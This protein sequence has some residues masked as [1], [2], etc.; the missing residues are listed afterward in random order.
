MDL[1]LTKKYRGK[2]RVKAHYDLQTKD[3]I[4]DDEGNLDP[5]FGDFYLSGRSGIE[6]K[7]GTGSELGCYIPKLQLG[8]NILKSYYDSV[9]GNRGDKSVDKIVSELK[10]GGYVNDVDILSTEIFFTFDADHLDAL[11][12]IIK[13]KTSG[14]SISPFSTRNL[15]KKPYT[16]P[17]TDMDRYK[18]AKDG[19]SGLEIARLNEEFIA[20][21]FDS[22]F[23]T[24][25]R[26][27][28]LKPIQY[29][30]KEK[31]WDKYCN[32]IEESKNEY[33]N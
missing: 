1:Y 21:N 23:K 13:L 8:N 7:H 3:F 28:M 24:N 2:Y 9:I 14:A 20:K 6:V 30:H 19:L 26:K 5:D 12:P 22:D 32:F 33:N 16:I 15:P 25:L 18:K 31:I 27:S 10:N 17:K 11:A 4:R 29:F